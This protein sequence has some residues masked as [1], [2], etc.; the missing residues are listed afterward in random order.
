LAHEQAVTE[1]PEYPTSEIAREDGEA[2]GRAA[3]KRTTQE[4]I[5]AGLSSQHLERA[6]SE[7]VTTIIARANALASAGLDPVIVS[8]WSEG[9]AEGFNSELDSAASLLRAATPPGAKH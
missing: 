3:G 9:A 4:I 8:A 2:F 7:G 5:G 1:R 6:G